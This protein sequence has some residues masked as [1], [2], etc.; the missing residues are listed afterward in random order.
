MHHSGTIPDLAPATFAWRSHFAFFSSNGVG[1][2]L[3]DVGTGLEG[4][5][6]LDEVGDT[7]DEHV[8][9]RD[10]GVS[11]SVGV[12][13]IVLTTL[14]GGV[15]TGST[16]GLES[17]LSADVLEVGSSGEL[18]EHDHAS[19][20]ETSSEVGRAG[21]DVT[22]MIGSHE[23]GAVLSEDVVDGSGGFAESLEDGVNV[24]T[25]LHG[26]DSGVILLV[27]PNKEVFGLVVENTTGVGPVATTSRGEEE[28]GIGLLEEVTS[29]SELS[30]VRL[31]HT[32]HLGGVR[33]GASKG[34][35][36]SCEITGETLESLNDE[37]L[38]LSSLF[39]AVAGGE[40]ES[41]EGSSG[42]ASGGED[43]L[44]GGVNLS[45]GKFLDV[46]VGGVYGIGG[47]TS[48]SGRDD[49]IH[50]VLEESPGL[51]ISGNESAGLDHGVTL[52]INTGLDA[53]TEVNSEFGGNSSVLGVELG[54]GLEDVGEVVVVLSEVG[55][56]LGHVLG[57]EGGSLLG[58]DVLLVSTSELNPLFSSSNH[59]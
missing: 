34:V 37:L 49:G 19:G 32:S 9:E 38:N 5:L 35:V 46:H 14:S 55:E 31:G 28:G 1:D 40:S 23:A 48:V 51:F 8:D 42:S 21:E 2:G 6:P 26:D 27:D 56:L 11:E 50:D 45:V 10:F 24:V 12:G 16:S 22:E 18:G 13:D 58:A 54:V 29:S 25:L 7:M 43:V 17:E 57:G 52:V 36:V 47:V 41:S 30:G 33:S 39:E 15:D 4:G 20:T 53:V 44:A 3:L 59:C